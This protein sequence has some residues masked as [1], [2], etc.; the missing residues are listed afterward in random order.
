MSGDLTK[1][2]ST[3]LLISQLV[4]L[5]RAGPLHHVPLPAVEELRTRDHE[6]ENFMKLNQR[7]HH[8]EFNEGLKNF[9]DTGYRQREPVDLSS[10][11]EYLVHKDPQ[12]YQGLQDL[13]PISEDTR[14][15]KI[16]SRS[17]DLISVHVNPPE[18][19]EDSNEEP[20]DADDV[21]EK[22]EKSKVEATDRSKEY[23]SK[24]ETEPSYK[25]LHELEKAPV[26]PAALVDQGQGVKAQATGTDSY[27]SISDVYL[28]AVI[29][30]CAVAALSGLIFAGVCWYR[31]HKKVKAASDVDYPAYG[32]TGPSSKEKSGSPGDRKLAQS[33]QMYHYQH[34]KQQMIASERVGPEGP[35]GGG[36]DG[37]SEEECE[38][39]DYTVFECPGLATTGEMEVRNPLFND[40]TPVATPAE[41]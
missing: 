7:L 37:E 25:E 1:C 30:G 23:Q 17:S 28:L 20:Y 27:T 3:L 34:Q 16:N 21:D 35:G 24:G 12:L 15:P 10:Y 38:E 8:K 13:G 41:K 29:A 5:T 4:L 14:F 11:Y 22:G 6:I 32:V 40:Q 33:A 31:L 2:Y 26:V 39:G 18:N 36:S 19:L 9:G